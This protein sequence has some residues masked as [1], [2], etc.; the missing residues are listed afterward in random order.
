MKKK[1][2]YDLPTRL[3]HWFFAA[4]FVFAFAIAKTVDDDSPIYVYHMMA[5]LTLG[6]LVVLRVIWGI[7]GTKH[8]RF[9]DLDLRPASLLQYFK[10]IL[11]GDKGRWAGH[12]PA[13]SLTTIV[14]LVAGAGMAL[15]G[16]LMTS[17]GDKQ[18]LE[19]VHEL[20]SDIFLLMV[21]AHVAGI[22][23]HTIRHREMIGLSMIDGRKENLP[24]AEEIPSSRP[25]VAFIF[26]VLVAAFMLNLSRHFDPTSGRLIFFGTTLQLSEEPEAKVNVEPHESEN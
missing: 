5:G 3:F 19:E 12:N 9:K 17:G 14:L 20:I 16:F 15:T 2:I 26:L 1:L 22:I 21:L 8:A 10:G 7:L 23:L 13:S 18:V 25:A 24:S 6:W 11:N 4:L